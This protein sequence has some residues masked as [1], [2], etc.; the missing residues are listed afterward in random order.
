M[1]AKNLGYLLKNIPIP[2]KLHY[3]KSK[4]DKVENF[5]IRLRWKPYFF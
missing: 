3:L 2:I 4:T 1:E 5:I